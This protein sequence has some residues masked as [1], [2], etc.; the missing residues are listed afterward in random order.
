MPVIGPHKTK[1]EMSNKSPTKAKSQR[2]VG[3][4]D[5]P[6]EMLIQVFQH[7]A[8]KKDLANIGQ[9]DRRFQKV[10]TELSEKRK[11][12]RELRKKRRLKREQKELKRELDELLESMMEDYLHE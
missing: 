11:K 8:K 3:L 12:L 7:L 9:V 10:C 5:L 6:D 2:R 4:Q 1:P